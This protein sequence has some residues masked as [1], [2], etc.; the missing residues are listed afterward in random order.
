MTNPIP[1][2]TR[3]LYVELRT[4]PIKYGPIIAALCDALVDAWAK[5]LEADWHR[6]NKHA[7]DGCHCATADRRAEADRLLRDLEVGK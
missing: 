4:F 6:N 5:A 3:R 2:E 1:I 7:G